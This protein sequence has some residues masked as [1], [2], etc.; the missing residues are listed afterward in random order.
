MKTVRDSFH[1]DSVELA[2][3]PSATRRQVATEAT[4]RERRHKSEEERPRE[5]EILA[6]PAPPTREAVRP[7]AKRQN[8][9]RMS[10]PHRAAV[11][12]RS[13]SISSPTSFPSAPVPPHT[14]SELSGRSKGNS[15]V[16]RSRDDVITPFSSS[17]D[18]LPRQPN[19][20]SRFRSDTIH[21]ALRF[22]EDA[23]RSSRFRS[24]LWIGSVRVP[25][26]RP[27]VAVPDDKQKDN[28]RETS[29]EPV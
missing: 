29:V 23:H 25:A 11:P 24:R 18:F 1:F 8:P 6:T 27:C 17:R 3:G 12:A 10:H 9:P 16:G 4:R 7:N 19:F 28:T 15:R 26:A 20:E 21:L 2:G 13:D 22:T 5:T 14:P